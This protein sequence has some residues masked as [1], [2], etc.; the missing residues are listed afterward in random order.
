VILRGM[1]AATEQARE[2]FARAMS[3][4]H[5]LVAIHRTTRNRGRRFREPT[6]N[7]AMV[8]LTAA[9]W[10]A[11]VQDTT[12]A[13]LSSLAVPHGDPGRPMFQAH[14]RCNTHL[15]R[16]LQHTKRA[17]YVHAVQ[18]R[19]VRSAS[20][21][22]LSRSVSLSVPTPPQA[23]K[24]RSTTG[25]IFG[26]GSPTARP[27]RPITSSAEGLGVDQNSTEATP[28]VASI[29]SKPLRRPLRS[30]RTRTSHS[31][32][33]KRRTFASMDPNEELVRRWYEVHGY[34]VRSNVPYSYR[35]ERGSGW[36]DVDL[37]V[38]HPRTG[39]AAAVEVKGW[40]TAAIS[41]SYLRAWGV[42]LAL[43]L[44]SSPGDQ[45]GRGSAWPL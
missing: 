36:S 1:S 17:Q 39:D 5:N 12:M 45:G 41:P 28:S 29:S 35:T 22:G 34:F 10:Q 30:R 6:L 16:T 27:F 2:D 13:I 37:C 21:A 18:Q 3:D 44:H 11:F 24:T 23:S 43:P 38:L 4:P 33:P 9:A 25:S 15:G 14:Q 20:P 7:R 42:A 40:H 31:A 32:R 19:R 26:T 8:V